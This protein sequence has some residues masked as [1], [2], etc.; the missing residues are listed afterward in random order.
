MTWTDYHIHSD[1]C[2]GEGSLKE[3]VEE[4]LKLKLHA[5]GFS[6]HAPSPCKLNWGMKQEDLDN[7]CASIRKLGRKYTEQMGIY[8]G[9]EVDYIPEIM[10]PR[11]PE[12]DALILDYVIG[13]VH[14]LDFFEDGRYWMVDANV[15]N[16]RDGLE[17]LFDGNIRKVV[18]EYYRRVRMMIEESCPDVVGHLDVVKMNNGD[19]RFF[20]EDEMW[21]QDAIYETLE[22][23][24]SHR[25][26]IEVN[27]GGMSRGR[28]KSPCPSPWILEQCL[29]M[30]IPVTLNSDSHNPVALTA[31]FK[32][33]ADMLISIGFR[34]LQILDVGG[35]HPCPFEAE[36]LLW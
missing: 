22:V 7:Y 14:V 27:T 29:R 2:D 25:T 31:F 34:E 5:I 13:S 36:G 33:M 28:I 21:Y 16:F 6:S 35:W 17:R 9:L 12:Y 20:S 8:L 26:V 19:E 11:N 1:Y 15:E 4:A 3:Y 30:G 32:P 18:E 10:S 24:S 23:I